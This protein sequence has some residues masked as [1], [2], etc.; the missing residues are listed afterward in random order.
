MAP[1]EAVDPD[2]AAFY[3]ADPDPAAFYNTN[4]DPALKNGKKI[5]L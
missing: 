2:P 1:C 3:N 5:N 4:P